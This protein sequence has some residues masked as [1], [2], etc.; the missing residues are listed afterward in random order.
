MT[1]YDPDYFPFYSLNNEDD[2]LVEDHGITKYT[3]K[4]EFNSF[5]RY[6]AFR[7]ILFEFEKDPIADPIKYFQNDQVQ[8]AMSKDPIHARR[9]NAYVSLHRG[10]I[11]ETN[12]R[13]RSLDQ[14]YEI[15]RQ[16]NNQYWEKLMKENS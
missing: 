12:R 15:A 6:E 11:R 14:A 8:E 13:Y 4:F 2:K 5:Q 9:V 3:N 1:V 16:Q 10:D 7:K